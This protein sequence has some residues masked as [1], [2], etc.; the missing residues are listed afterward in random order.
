MRVEIE[1]AQIVFRNGGCSRQ[2]AENIS[3]LTF[4]Y[5]HQM[6]VGRR[7]S[8]DRRLERIESTPLRLALGAMSDQQ[9]ARAAARAVFRAVASTAHVE[10]GS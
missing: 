10:Q 3:R 2:R 7:M 8:N 9:V 1:Q 6:M 4:E 5:V